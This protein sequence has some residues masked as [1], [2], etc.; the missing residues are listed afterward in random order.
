MDFSFDNTLFLIEFFGI[1]VM[2]VIIRFYS[3][4]NYLS[5][6]KQVLEDVYFTVKKMKER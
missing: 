6:E 2:V 3:I 5:E 4:Y 1:V